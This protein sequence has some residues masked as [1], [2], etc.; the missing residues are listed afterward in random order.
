MAAPPNRIFL[1]LCSVCGPQCIQNEVVLYG[2][3]L[4]LQYN[5]REDVIERGGGA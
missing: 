1:L 5:R 3:V 4:C 2:T